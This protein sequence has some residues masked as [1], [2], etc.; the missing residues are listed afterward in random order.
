MDDW[1]HYA[2]A[3]DFEY[4]M[5]ICAPA[6]AKEV[7]MPEFE[8]ANEDDASLQGTGEELVVLI[9]RFSGGQERMLLWSI[10]K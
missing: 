10:V 2:R 8:A 6:K 5:P 4:L 7:Y 3:P 1:P 9:K